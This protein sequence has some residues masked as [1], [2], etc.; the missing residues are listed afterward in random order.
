VQEDA[1]QLK[2][3]IS[4]TVGLFSCFF[5]FSLAGCSKN[6]TQIAEP[7]KTTLTEILPTPSEPPKFTTTPDAEMIGS[8]PHVSPYIKVMVVDVEIR[9]LETNPVEVELVIRGTLPD[10]CKY[11]FY[12][13]ENRSG[14]NIK[15]SLDGIH[16][17]DT[18]CLQTEQSIEYVL[19]LGRDMPQAERGFSSGDYKLTVNSYQGYFSIK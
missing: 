16:P 12:S 13:V 3:Q 2:N 8:T 4:V 1:M 19:P 5:L 17:A 18:G 10:Q 7:S 6:T 15:V 14:Q 9:F 11:N